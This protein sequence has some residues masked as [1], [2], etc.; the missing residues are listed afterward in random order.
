LRANARNDFQHKL[1]RQL[2]DDNPAMIVKI[3]KVKNMMKNAKLVQPIGDASWRA[4]STKLEYKTKEQSKH[5]VKIDPWFAC[6]KTCHTCQ[7]QREAMLL[8]TRSWD[9]PACHA[10]H[11]RDINAALN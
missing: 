6:S 10:H 5:L 11:D 1:S 7:H 4:L 3:L 8:N 9:C 2:I